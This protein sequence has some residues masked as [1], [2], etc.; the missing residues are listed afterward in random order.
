MKKAIIILNKIT[1]VLGIIGVVA[2]VVYGLI[3][4]ISGFSLINESPESAGIIIGSGIGSV[5]GSLFGIIPVILAKKSTEK[6]E[7][8]LRKSDIT[9]W[10]IITLILVNTIS[11][12]LML[13]ID[14]SEFPL[15]HKANSSVDHTT[16]TTVNTSPKVEPKTEVDPMAEL[17][18]LKELLDAGIIT[19]E[20]YNEKRQ[21]YIDRL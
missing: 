15:G 5:I 20:E 3:T 9:V 7:T 6:V 2:G 13:V 4:A 8:A 17:K 10:A 21:K 19:E 14:E 12:I 16:T 1:M 18:R 11:G